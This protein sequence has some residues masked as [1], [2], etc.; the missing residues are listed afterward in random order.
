MEKAKTDKTTTLMGVKFFF[1]TLFGLVA[2]FCEMFLIIPILSPK[3]ALNIYKT[4]GLNKAA[5]AT[6]ERIYKKNNKIEN[7]YNLVLLADELNDSEN[8][9]KY[10]KIMLEREEFSA[11]SAAFDKYAIEH[12]D[13]DKQYLVASL[14]SYLIGIRIEY[15]Y[16]KNADLA[17]VEAIKSFDESDF[18]VFYFPKF[19]DCILVDKNLTNAQKAQTIANLASDS[20]TYKDK[21]IIELLQ[22]RYNANKPENLEAA[23][24]L[25]IEE[26]WQTK[27]IEATL[28]E[29][30]NDESGLA[31]ARIEISNLSSIV[32][33]KIK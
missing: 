12:A 6:S 30:K 15:L 28:L 32:A 5:L 9:L 29:A 25:L 31:A 17:F 4:A 20:V 10:S 7:L 11:F 8:L 33:E 22:E 14:K 2:I 16:K 18:N 24:L 26:L 21:T 27:T 1:L 23:E 3:T 19:I 13:K